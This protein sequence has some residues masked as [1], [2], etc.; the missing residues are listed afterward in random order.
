MPENGIA[1]R[2]GSS[3][4][5]TGLPT[6]SFSHTS[7]R[8]LDHSPSAQE[9]CP[10]ARRN[11]DDNCGHDQYDE[12]SPELNP[13]RVD[14]S[15][16][17]FPEALSPSPKVNRRLGSGRVHRRLQL[18]AMHLQDVDSQTVLHIDIT[19]VEVLH[20][21]P[22]SLRSASHQQASQQVDSSAR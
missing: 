3:P 15:Q 8:K 12:Y 11:Q 1:L 7:Y 18:G 22:E 21:P 20:Y 9:S 17:A 2:G 13:W 14:P 19:G 4:Y 6:S 10:P 16:Y 5:R